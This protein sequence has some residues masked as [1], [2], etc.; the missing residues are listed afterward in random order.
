MSAKLCKIAVWVQIWVHNFVNVFTK[1]V[2]LPSDDKRRASARNDLR[3]VIAQPLAQVARPEAEPSAVEA[4]MRERHHGAMCAMPPRC[5]LVD[6]G[7]RP[8]R[9][10][11]HLLHGEQ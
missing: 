8:S 2:A 7:L 10:F 11:A 9:D 6:R 5:A 3:G 4:T 1:L